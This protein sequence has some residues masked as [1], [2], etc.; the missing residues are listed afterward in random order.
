MKKVHEMTPFSYPI[1]FFFLLFLF[2]PPLFYLSILFK[3]CYLLYMSELYVWIDLFLFIFI[4]YFIFCNFVT[5]NYKIL[6]KK[7]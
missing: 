5:V 6:R 7:V 1:W 3:S 4:F 2:F